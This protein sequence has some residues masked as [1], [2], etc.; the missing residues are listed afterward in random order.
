MS[1]TEGQH[2]HQTEL[3]KITLDW[4]LIVVRLRLGEFEGDQSPQTQIVLE[5][6]QVMSGSK[7]HSLNIKE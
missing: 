3:S 7:E 1:P 6:R 5:V 2:L 4:Q